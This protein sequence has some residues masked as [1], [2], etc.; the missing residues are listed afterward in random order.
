MVTTSRSADGPIPIPPPCGCFRQSPR[1]PSTISSAPGEAPLRFLHLSPSG[2]GGILP[3]TSLPSARTWR[4]PADALRA[5]D[6]ARHTRG[7]GESEGDG[8]VTSSLV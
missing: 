1:P 2:R 7:K 8:A 6:C 5:G 3:L 4:H